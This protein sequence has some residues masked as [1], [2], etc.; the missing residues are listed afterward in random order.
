MDLFDQLVRVRLD[1]VVFG[2]DDAGVPRARKVVEDRRGP[3]RVEHVAQREDQ[4][5]VDRG[6]RPLR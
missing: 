1:L 2:H 5:L 4:D 3:I 6:D